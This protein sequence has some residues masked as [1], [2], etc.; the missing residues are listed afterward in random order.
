MYPVVKVTKEASGNP[1]L[2]LWAFILL[3]VLPVSAWA[4][5]NK[6]NKP[7]DE[8]RIMWLE[9][10]HDQ[11]VERA[12]ALAQW[13]DDFFGD[14][15]DDLEQAESFLRTEFIDDW[16]DEDGHNIKVRLRGKI[17][18]PKI[19][20]RLDLAFAGD[21]NE[22]DPSP[23]ERNEGDSVSLK[24]KLTDKNKSRFDLSLGA[25]TGGLRPGVRFRYSN[26]I[27][28]R[29]NYRFVERVQ[30]ENDEGFYSTTQLDLYH[31]IGTDDSLRWSNR[32]R[33]GEETD[34]R[35]WRT[36][37]SLRK[38]YLINTKRPMATRAVV[39]INGVTEPKSFTKNYKLSFSF[40]RQIYSDFLFMELQP[41]YNYRRRNVD[42][43]RHGVWSLMF[44]LEMALE[45]DL[46]RKKKS[47]KY[48]DQAT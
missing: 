32:L 29:S 18:L 3:F 15:I 1:A 27:G 13:M 39:S 38:R 6:E 19:S 23:E 44:K 35:E 12:Q 41:A 26:S 36:S 31:A 4:D 33:Y 16:E 45:K 7:I 21:E 43:Q 17:Q 48:E 9:K 11:S 28:N 34:G 40:R 5:E 42:E 10:N 8:P 46:R 22:A 30:H 47:K 20:K 2:K 14:P 37:L 24:Y 25:S